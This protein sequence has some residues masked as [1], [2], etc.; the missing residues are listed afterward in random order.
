M[1]EPMYIRFVIN[2][3]DEDSGRRQG[4]FQAMQDLEDENVLHGYELDIYKEIYGWFKQHLEAPSSFSRSTRSSSKEV[5]LSWFKPSATE[6][7]R[8]MYEVANI[9]ESH[10]VHVEVIRSSRPGYV[11]YEDEFQ[12]TAEPFQSTGA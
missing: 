12:V 4:L 11:V 9:L 1:L 2:K 8:K 6:H 5:A 10:G 7:I 3:K